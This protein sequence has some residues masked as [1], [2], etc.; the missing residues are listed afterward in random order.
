MN[1]PAWFTVPAAIACAAA[2]TV[3]CLLLVGAW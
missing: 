1:A 2:L 3:M